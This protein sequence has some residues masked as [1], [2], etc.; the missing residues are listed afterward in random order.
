MR[1]GASAGLSLETVQS[2]EF[3][4]SV[5]RPRALHLADSGAGVHAINSMEYVV[6][7]SLRPNTTSIATANGIA[8]PP[9]QC[10][11]VLSVLDV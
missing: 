4:G 8:T 9:Y 10:D 7:G 3:V 11:A 5:V 1:A 6:P 2:P